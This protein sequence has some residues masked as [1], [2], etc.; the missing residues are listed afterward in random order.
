MQLP[1]SLIIL[2]GITA[3]L[4][5]GLVNVTQNLSEKSI[6]VSP[7]LPPSPHSPAGGVEEAPASA[8]AACE[9]NPTEMS[10]AG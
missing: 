2:F 5:V 6:H 1:T 8:I 7:Q 9:L 4:T 3:V 10:E